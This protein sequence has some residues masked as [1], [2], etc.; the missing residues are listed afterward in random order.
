[1]KTA[2]VILNYNGANLLQEYLPGVL[3]LTPIG[4]DIIVVDNGSQDNSESIVKS[5]F[6]DVQFISLDR[7]YGFA[8][9]YNR[10]LQALRGKYRYYA[11]LNSDVEIKEDWVSPIVNL[12]EDSSLIAACQPKIKSLRQPE[13][14]EYAGAAGG[15]IDLLGYPF[16]RGRIFETTEM[17]LGQYDQITEVYWA[18]GAAMVVRADIFHEIGGFDEDFFA[19]MEEIDLCCRLKRKGYAVMAHGK[20]E[21]YHLGGASLSYANPEKIYLNFRNNLLFLTK[22]KSVLSL[23]LMIPLRLIL[24]GIAGISFM[25]KGNPE[26]FN[27]VIR[28]HFAYYSLFGKIWKKRKE[29]RKKANQVPNT[30]GVY[31]GS[32]L[33][34]Y[35]LLGNRIFQ[36]IQPKGKGG[37]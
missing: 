8:G 32:I 29:A 7:N 15:W 28:A 12:M 2:L 33:L 6:A 19:H 37:I 14:F 21:V 16:C 11:L 22:N 31:K 24:D 20:S 9:G 3:R 36:I 27:A 10:G 1:V 13:K 26:G 25:I 23:V 34:Q 30:T 35:Y 17:D 5:Q 4:I 18:S